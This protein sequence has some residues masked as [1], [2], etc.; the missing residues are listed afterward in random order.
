MSAQILN[1]AIKNS[2]HYCDRCKAT[3]PAIEWKLEVYQ[4]SLKWR[5]TVCGQVD[6][7]PNKV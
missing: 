6:R 5:H 7:V 1:E 3:F 2:G 4:E